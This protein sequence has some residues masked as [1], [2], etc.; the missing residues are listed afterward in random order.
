MGKEPENTAEWFQDQEDIQVALGYFFKQLYQT[1][2]AAVY[3]GIAKQF[4]K[5]N[6]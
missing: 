5:K 1:M 6:G 2:E 4:S 3:N